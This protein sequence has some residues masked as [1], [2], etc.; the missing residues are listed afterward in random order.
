MAVVLTERADTGREK[1]IRPQAVAEQ[2][3]GVGTRI[4]RATR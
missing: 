4:G 3:S 2:P 1:Q